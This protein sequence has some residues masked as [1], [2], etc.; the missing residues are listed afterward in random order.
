MNR[1]IGIRHRLKKTKEGEARPTQL[2]VIDGE[3]IET[4]ELE[5]DNAELDWVRGRFPIAW[6]DIAP[7]DNLKDFNLRHVKWRTVKKGTD[8][9]GL[10]A[11]HL[12]E[13]DGKTQV[14]S[15]VPITFDGLQRAD[16]VGMSLG[17]SGDRLAFALSKQGERVG[18]T[19][20]RLPPFELKRERRGEKDEDAKLLAE[21]ANRNPG[22]FHEVTPTTRR[23]IW[24]RECQALRIDAMKGRIACEQ[25]LRQA[26]VGQVL[27]TEQDF[28][29]LDIER[30]FNA[31]KANDRIYMALMEEEAIRLKELDRAVKDTQV[32]QHILEDVSGIGPALAGRLIS[33]I[34]GIE[35]FM[36]EPDQARMDSLYEESVRLELEGK[37]LELKKYVAAG[38]STFQTL[39]RV[40]SWCR[41]NQRPKE[42]ALLARA[43]AC[44]EER[45]KLRRDARNKGRGKLKSFCGVAVQ[46]GGKF[47][48]R[49]AGS[50]ANWH[51]DA[52]Q[53]LFLLAD[54]FN[55]QSNRTR[56]GAMLLDYKIKFRAAHPPEKTTEGKSRYSDGHIHKMALWRTV[57]KFVE[58]LYDQWSD[59]A[60]K[61]K[62]ATERA[63]MSA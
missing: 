38:E 27:C 33:S 24:V 10:I 44:H 25:R 29:E 4:Y 51:P 26:L 15:K 59:L 48:R 46:E 20:L 60:R 57:T 32:W 37:F 13:E 42:A 50:V 63:K 39:Q 40:A 17:G 11:G 12:R 30:A 53:A 43:V 61:Q 5:D 58:F 54:Q 14:A 21:L 8:T 56:W 16:V 55:R 49:R 19:V 62:L 34:G 22:L 45:S 18:A 28:A 35:R 9:S 36:V 7:E 23:I 31:L 3:N 47:P 1:F 2:C 52:R 6:R 41:A